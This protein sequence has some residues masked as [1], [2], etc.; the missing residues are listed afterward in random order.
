MEQCTKHM[1]VVK[2]QLTSCLDLLA[3]MASNARGMRLTD[4]ATNLRAPKSSTQRL[5]EH[6]ASEGWIEQDE[7]TSQYRLTTRLAVLGHRYLESA[8]IA[9]IA[10]ALLER[11]AMKTGELARL[12]VL[13]GKR[14]VWMGSA[15]GAPCGLRYE[16]SMGSAIVSYATANG[17]AWLATLRDDDAIAIAVS[18]GLGPPRKQVATGPNV[19]RTASELV[20]DLRLTRKRGYAVS[21][22]EAEQGV[23]AVAVAI[24]SLDGG[25]LGTTSVAG[26]V[27]R[28]TR[29]R[30][31]A[32]VPAL[33]GVAA[34]LALG[35]PGN[36]A[37]NSGLRRGR[38]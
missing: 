4:L 2:S 37:R 33:N 18:D 20:A 28:L 27:I 19:I 8:G 35:W 5:L 6:L 13:D 36:V 25:V 16:P 15:Q 17:K 23:A 21:N 34:D 3:V 10:Q 30:Y 31:A 22:E 24:H 38:A 12:T 26:P 32:I 9:N 11:L 29:E 14:L 7:A 1:R